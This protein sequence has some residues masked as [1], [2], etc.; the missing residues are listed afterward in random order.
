MRILQLVAGEKWTGA[1][2]VVF[3]QTAALVAAGVE[4]QFGFVRESPLAARLLPLGWARP[5]LSP[6][7]TPLRYPRDVRTVAQ[8]LRREGF[9]VVHC[10]GSHDHSVAAAARRAA[11]RGGPLLARTI[12]SLDRARGD[13]FSRALFRA[14]DVLAFANRA[15]AKK[16]GRDGPVL[17]PVVD[18]G[19]FHPGERPVERLRSLGVPEAGFVVGTVGKL[20][21]RRGHREAIEVASTLPSDVVLLHVGKGELRRELESRAAALGSGARNF[22]A[23]YVENDLPDYYRAMDVFLFPASG[24]EQG[25]R[26]LLE[27]MACG[28]PVVALDVPG[29]RDLVTHEREGLVVSR[30]ADMASAL[31]RMRVGSGERRRMGERARARAL[32]FGPGAFAHEAREFYARLF[33]RKSMTSRAWVAGDTEG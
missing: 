17:S 18:P 31:E 1:A 6:A 29:V 20:A 28:V 3:D 32:E 2:A 9:D 23:G 33:A 30:P 13:P 27:A 11:R 15:I 21:P 25:Q 14:T 26:A 8:M 10:H 5:L 16:L 12:H 19:R 22:W 4:A 7:R 24:S